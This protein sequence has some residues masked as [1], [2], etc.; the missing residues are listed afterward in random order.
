DLERQVLRRGSVLTF[1]SPDGSTVA[2]DAVRAAVARGVGLHT[3]VGL[4]EVLVQP[5]RLERY[6]IDE[7]AATAPSRTPRPAAKA[8]AAPDDALYR[9]AA[10]QAERRGRAMELFEHARCAADDGARWRVP[11]S[12]WGALRQIARR[13]RI[14]GGTDALL[15]EVR[16]QLT[17]GI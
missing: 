17:E 15:H 4:G 16:K 2:L 13:A 5:A 14:A 3:N 7:H 12:Q 1:A 10:T 6:R 9:W 8:A 11:A